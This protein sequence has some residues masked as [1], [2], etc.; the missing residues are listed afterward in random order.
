MVYLGP[1]STIRPTIKTKAVTGKS[2]EHDMAVSEVVDR[3]GELEASPKVERRRNDRRREDR[4]VLVDT[5][6]NDRRGRLKIDIEV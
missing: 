2:Q 3:L 5:R 4:D 6:A 1:V